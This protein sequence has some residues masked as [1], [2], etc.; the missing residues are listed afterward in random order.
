MIPTAF[1][2]LD[3]LPLTPTGK[4]DRDALPETVISRGRPE[5]DV[6]YAAPASPLERTL[7]GVWADVLGL[8]GVGSQDDF[9]DLG[10]SSLE[11]VR[12]LAQVLA[13]CGEELSWT[14]MFACPTVAG[15]V[16]AIL[17]RRAQR[18]HLAAFEQILAEVEALR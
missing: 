18:V 17:Q 7:A 4:V 14:D 11:A 3:T 5:L 12:I 9:A 1:V 15:M 6:S 13:T 10:G 8:D 2:A 16:V